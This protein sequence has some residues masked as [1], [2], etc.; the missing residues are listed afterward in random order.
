MPRAIFYLLKGD[1]RYRLD[2]VNEIARE[3]RGRVEDIRERA[4][5]Q[6]GAVGVR[7]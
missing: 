6:Q 4:D 2:V 3:Q 1:Y 7:A 5:R